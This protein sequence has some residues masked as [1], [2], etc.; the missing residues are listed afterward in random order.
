MGNAESNKN[1]IFSFSEGTIMT[2]SKEEMDRLNKS[3]YEDMREFDNN[4]TQKEFNS[5]IEASNT[6][7]GGIHI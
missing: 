2:M 1:K 7:I 4:A 5:L 3:L 6:F